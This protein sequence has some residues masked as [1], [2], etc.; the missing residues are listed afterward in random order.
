MNLVLDRAIS[1]RWFLKV[2]TLLLL[3]GC[4]P[5]PL[6]EDALQEKEF[7]YFLT[8]LIPVD[9]KHLNKFKSALPRLLRKIDNA[10]KRD[11]S[12]TYTRF[13]KRYVKNYAK[14]PFSLSNGESIIAEM[15]SNKSLS[16]ETNSA[17]DTLYTL[18]LASPAGDVVSWG[19]PFS[20]P[21]VK[22]LYWENYDEPVN[23][24]KGG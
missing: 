2:L 12:N 17:L 13:K 21:G 22:C 8:T 19:R 4:G 7:S 6:L 18:F 3:E 20:K 11:I 5:A 9:E 16:D 15:L 1:R 24:V 10:R 14:K 23:L